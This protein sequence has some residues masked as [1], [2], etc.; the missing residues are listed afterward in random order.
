M[1][2]TGTVHEVGHEMIGR[3]RQS[4]IKIKVDRRT[5]DVDEMERRVEK[6]SQSVGKRCRVFVDE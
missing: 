2:I 3:T 1:K 5:R 4:Y 6:Y